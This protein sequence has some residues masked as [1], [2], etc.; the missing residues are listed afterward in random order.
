MRIKSFNKLNGFFLLYSGSFLVTVVNIENC[1]DFMEVANI[2]VMV[3]AW[4]FWGGVEVF[5]K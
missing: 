3:K 1:K 5:C 2:F 4:G